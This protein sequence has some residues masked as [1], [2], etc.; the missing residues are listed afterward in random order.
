MAT[1]SYG[2]LTLPYTG[3]DPRTGLRK[4][5]KIVLTHEELVK[6]RAAILYALGMSTLTTHLIK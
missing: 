2:R 6:I 3:R 5:L 4:Y 1:V